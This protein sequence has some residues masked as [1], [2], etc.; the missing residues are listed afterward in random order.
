MALVAS[1][2]FYFSAK[3]PQSYFDY[4]FRI[5]LSL[6]RGH[7]GLNTPPPS[8][9]SEMVPAGGKYYSV[10]PLG[11]VLV[12]IPAAV[13]RRIGLVHA[14]PARE[15]AA[16][17][18][19]GCVYFFYRLSHLMEM[20]RARRVLLALFPVFGTWTWCNLGFGGHGR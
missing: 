19:G 2:L 20:T 10:F 11:A 1:T 9:L 5:A 15:L 14:W 18:A 3:A 13:L 4:T 17:I 16:A 6:L 7:A 8:W 12:N